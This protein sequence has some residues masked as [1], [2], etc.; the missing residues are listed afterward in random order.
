MILVQ[1]IKKVICNTEIVNVIIK[2]FAKKASL[3]KKEKENL[4]FGGQAITFMQCVRFLNDYLNGDI[5]YKI[6]YESQNLIRAKN[7]WAFYL[8]LRKIKAL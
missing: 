8:S 3:E 1:E 5:Y 6:S 4:F 2:E 7:Q